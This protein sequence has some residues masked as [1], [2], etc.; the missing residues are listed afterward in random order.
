VDPFT[1]AGAT[2][3]TDSSEAPPDPMT[4]ARS[5]SR[6]AKQ[7]IGS[8]PQTSGS[9]GLREETSQAAAAATDAAFAASDAVRDASAQL[10]DVAKEALRATTSAVSAQVAEIAS[11]V[12]DELTATAEVQKE[13]GAEAMHRLARAARSAAQELDG[14]S[15]QVARQIRAAAGSVDSLSDN[16]HGRSVDELFSSASDF[17]RS[18]PAAFFAGAVIA[19]FAFARFLKSSS[20]PTHQPPASRQSPPSP[21]PAAAGPSPSAPSLATF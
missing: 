12:K 2:V 1:P 13:H 6:S 3:T 19:G 11:S 17:A 21:T 16:I 9:V 18:Q 15:P 4:S 10:A 8:E 5:H 14:S 7:G 20:E